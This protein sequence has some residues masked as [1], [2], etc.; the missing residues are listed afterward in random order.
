MSSNPTSSP[1]A[2]EVNSLTMQFGG[3]K[4]VSDVN[5]QVPEKMIFG[6]IGPNG[7]G[8]TTLFNMLTGV[9]QPSAGQIKA[10]GKNLV[11][12]R[13]HEITHLGVARTFQNVRLFKDLTVLDNV[14]IALDHHPKQQHAGIF[15]TIFR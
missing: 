1:F 15:S 14:L 13:P 5:L 3:L 2:L 6:V 8:K 12:H 10:F 7:A 4:A 11:G 9:Y